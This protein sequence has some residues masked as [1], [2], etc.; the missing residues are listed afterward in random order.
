MAG[1]MGRFPAQ[2]KQGWRGGAPAAENV[3]DSGCADRLACAIT[4]IYD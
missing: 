4:Y 2:G 1:N 3:A